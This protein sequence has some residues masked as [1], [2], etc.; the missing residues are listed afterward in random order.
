MKSPM[1]SYRRANSLFWSGSIILGVFVVVAV[2]GPMFFSSSA[3]ALDAPNGR[4]SPS[5][6]HPL[7]TDSFGRDILSR[8]LVSTRLT[9][10]LTFGSSLI[11]VGIG[12]LIGVT[13]WL[14]GRRTRAAILQLNSVAVA[15]PSMI[16]ALVVAAIMGAGSL[17]AM[18]AVGIA[19]VPT[20]IR[21]TASM[22]QKIVSQDFVSI[23]RLQGVSTIRLAIR[24]ILPN[25][26][27]PLSVM[28]ANSTA[29][30]LVELSSLSFIGLGVQAPD[31]DFGKMLNDG[32]AEMSGQP[33]GVFG[34]S[35]AIVLLGLGIMLFGDGLAAMID[36]KV[37]MKRVS[38]RRAVR[39]AALGD[40]APDRR[41]E[42]EVVRAATVKNL[43]I[44]VTDP[45][46]SHRKLVHGVSFEIRAGEIL[47]IV[48][49]SGSGKSLTAMTVA[50]LTPAGLWIEAD[51]LSVEGIDMR[52]KA[53][54]NALARTISLVYQD[55]MSTFSPS[56]RMGSQLSDIFRQH[57]KWK[58]KTTNDSL[59]QAFESVSVSEPGRRLRQF[60]HELSGGLLQRTL[61]AQ[62]VLIGPR[63]L[64][65]DEPT[66]A[67]DVSVQA[68]VLRKIYKFRSETGAGVLFISHDLAVVEALCDRVLVMYQG[69]FVEE[70][71]PDQIRSGAVKHAY[72][73]RLLNAALYFDQVETDSE[74]TRK[75]K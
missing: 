20:Y 37:A 32:L 51:Q 15:F 75:V 69:E 46:G 64:I 48:G 67:L 24:H 33:W 27:I 19:G 68:D 70:L 2:F 56:L 14:I 10:L 52:K 71:R 13:V 53:D 5:V 22:S 60:P 39:V 4:L 36:P 54:D 57:L 34:P 42:S 12:T 41:D 23:A 21:L 17:S 44:G 26:A 58:R 25:I 55:P 6:E 18:L 43:S 73:K 38:R 47:G 63:L 29:F 49:E 35:I 9:L 61:I 8:V 30:T 65:A 11:A 72:T 66:T 62:S 74:I 16:L 45:D 3:D 7:G 31:Y 59:L 40:T 50:G 28:A 1:R